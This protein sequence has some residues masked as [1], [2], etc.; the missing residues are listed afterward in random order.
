MQIAIHMYLDDGNSAAQGGTDR[1]NCGQH[2]V[3]E[4]LENSSFV[5][6]PAKCKWNSS[7]TARWLGFELDLEKGTVS[8]PEE[9]ITYSLKGETSSHA[10]IKACM[11]QTLG[12]HSWD[13]DIHEFG[14]WPCQLLYDM[15]Y[16][17][18]D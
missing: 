6:H 11:C 1:G 14:Y 9:K 16:A 4:T 17:Y 12:L 15:L 3:R 18:A 7:T 2:D 13:T 5:E 10:R 8:V